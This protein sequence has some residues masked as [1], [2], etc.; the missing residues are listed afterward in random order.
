MYSVKFIGLV[1]CLLAV[2]VPSVHPQSCNLD[3]A[4]LL[5]QRRL[6]QLRA[7]IIAQLG[8]EEEPTNTPNITSA[9][10][11]SVELEKAMATWNALRSARASME[12]EQERK[13]RSDDFFAKPV[14]SF[15]GNMSPRGMY[16]PRI[17]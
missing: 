11:S 1:A 8:L 15:V 9:P 5:Q 6:R 13:C 10:P 2:C 12:R 14:T 7:N 3:N 17:M 4:E 16:K